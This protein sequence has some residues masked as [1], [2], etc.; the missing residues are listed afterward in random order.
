MTSYDR[1]TDEVLFELIKADDES[2]FT[3]LYHRYKRPLVA[4]AVK[5]MEQEGVEDLV[6]DLFVKLWTNRHQIQVHQLVKSYLYRSLRNKILDYIVHQSHERKYYDSLVMYS[7]DYIESADYSIREKQ[8]MLELDKLMNNYNEQ[9]KQIIK[10]RMEGYSNVEIAV[11]LG[12]SEKTIRNRYS[13]ITKSLGSKLKI[14]S[15]FFLF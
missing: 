7:Q 15:I 13:L 10:M 11:H 14:V 1:Q 8:F 6:H 4:L 12:L 9:D 2:A 3:E 5:K